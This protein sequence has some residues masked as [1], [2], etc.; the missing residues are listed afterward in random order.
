MKIAGFLLFIIFGGFIY[1]RDVELVIV[2]ETRD[3]EFSEKKFR[4]WTRFFPKTAGLIDASRLA[5]PKDLAN[6]KRIVIPAAPRIFSPEMI[7]GMIQ[8]VADGGLIIT[9]S[10][11]NG[12]DANGDF[13]EDFSLFLAPAKRKKGHP[14][15]NGWPPS[16]VIAHST[17]KIESVT[18]VIECPLSK[19]FTV[20]K[21]TPVSFSFRNVIRADGNVIFTA[22]A[23][24]KNGRR[25]GSMPLVSVYN[26]GKGTF[27]FIPFQIEMLVK[28][29]LS[30]ET[31]DWL[32]D[33]E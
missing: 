29:A 16:G 10:I 31:L 15:P 26:V 25:K 19:G 3:P 33:Q 14:R 20:N 22:S 13:R 6:I 21:L 30:T 12:I 27:V 8:Y 28:N 23:V 2:K 17:M 1:A 24:A 9:E 18:A 5:R 4:N 11:M 32:T 7:D